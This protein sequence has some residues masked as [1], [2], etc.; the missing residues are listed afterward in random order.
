VI[1]D[2]E[3]DRACLEQGEIAFLIGRDQPKRM[4]VQMRGFRLCLERDKALLRGREA[5]D[6]AVRNQG[7]HPAAIDVSEYRPLRRRPRLS[8]SRGTLPCPLSA[9]LPT[10]TRR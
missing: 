1:G 4:K 3:D 2:V 9:Q 8:G 7:F 6:A 10:A 5:R